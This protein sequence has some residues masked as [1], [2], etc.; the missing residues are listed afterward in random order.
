MRSTRFSLMA[1]LASAQ[2]SFANNRDRV[3][4][5]IEQFLVR[6]P[7]VKRPHPEIG[8]VVYPISRTPFVVLYDFDD[9]TPRVHFIFHRSSSL[10][11]LD[12]SSA[13]W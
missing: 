13:E 9:E 1:S 4:L 8:L 2:L 3:L 7:K 6:F 5:T 10:D 11:D 12:P